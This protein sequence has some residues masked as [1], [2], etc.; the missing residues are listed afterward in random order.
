MHARSFLLSYLTPGWPL[1][2]S[3]LRKPAITTLSIL[4]HR[5]SLSVTEHAF[6]QPARF[7]PMPVRLHGGSPHQYRPPATIRHLSSSSSTIGIAQKIGSCHEGYGDEAPRPAALGVPEG[8]GRC[9]WT[10]CT[11]YSSFSRLGH[12][13]GKNPCIW[14]GPL[15]CL[16]LPDSGERLRQAITV[17]PRP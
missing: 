11:R 1:F 5:V 12:R 3:S 17:G 15:F 4:C 7:P 10:T 14:H 16:R 2:T 9:P 8:L 13:H 6:R